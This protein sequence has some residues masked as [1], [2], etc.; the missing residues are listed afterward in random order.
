MKLVFDLLPCK[1]KF[2]VGYCSGMDK[3][4]ITVKLSKSRTAIIAAF[5]SFGTVLTAHS[6]VLETIESLANEN[7]FS[8]GAGD[9]GQSFL[10]N[11]T[12]CIESVAFEAHDDHV[13]GTLSI[14]EGGDETRT[15]IYS[16][17]GP[18]WS[19]SEL[20]DFILDA[21]VPVT[22]GQTYSVNSG[23]EFLRGST[24]DPY[25][26]GDLLSRD[27]FPSLAGWDTAFRIVI[28][29]CA[30]ASYTVGGSVSGLTGSVTLQNNGVDDLV[31]N[32]DGS[33]TFSTKLADSSAYAVTVS[34]QPTG[35]TCTVTGGANGDGTG[36]ITG[37]DVANIAV[38]CV[39]DPMPT[40]SVGGT[41]TG[42]D[43]GGGTGC[44][45]LENNGV[46]EVFLDNGPFTFPTE[47]ADGGGYSV[48]VAGKPED[49]TCTVSNGSG[50]ISAADVTDVIVACQDNEPPVE[51][52]Q[53]PM[54][55]TPIPTL[56][57]WAIITL[58]ML[59]GVLGAVRLRRLM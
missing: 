9:L 25:P 29:D 38:A 30:A 31:V 2:I 33:F 42:L 58:V 8:G 53:A 26:D 46:D 54:S 39:S 19:Q 27:G 37:A 13:A 21:P 40:Y 24:S 49:Q 34:S 56:S 45:W 7:L 59:L 55:S 5:L 6:A 16:Q 51:P 28:V 50:T 57:E 17:P 4:Q 18:I 47:L 3:E 10:V 23:I 36:T 22:A 1:S 35:Q 41:V 48:T 32:A 14:Y 12:G 44:L 15:Q 11:Q 52:P 20:V 43:C